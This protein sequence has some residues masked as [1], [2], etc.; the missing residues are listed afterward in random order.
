MLY[1]L[2]RSSW[3]ALAVAVLG[4]LWV[5]GCGPVESLVVINQANLAIEAAERSEAARYAPYEYYSA[6]ELVHKAREEMNYSDFEVAVDL[7][8]D[9]KKL[10]SKAR[11]KAITHPERTTLPPADGTAPAA[12]DRID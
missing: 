5:A 4:S 8:L 9:A 11:E 2:N 6:V 1:H 3:L 12:N 10:A 7:A